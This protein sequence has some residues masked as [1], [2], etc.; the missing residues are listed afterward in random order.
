MSDADG[1]QH[2]Q[3]SNEFVQAGPTSNDSVSYSR[4]MLTNNIH[5]RILAVYVEKCMSTSTAKDWF[6][7]FRDG[8]QLRNDSATTGLNSCCVTEEGL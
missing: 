5:E 8:Q 4:R 2:D 1:K 7:M 6:Q 3:C